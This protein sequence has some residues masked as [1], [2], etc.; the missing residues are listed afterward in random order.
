MASIIVTFALDARGR[1]HGPAHDHA[2]VRPEE[3]TRRHLRA[4]TAADRAAVAAAPCSWMACRCRPACYRSRTWPGDAS[5]PSR[6]ITPADGLSPLQHAFVEH[7]GYQCG[8]CTPGMLMVAS[9]LLDANP[10]PSRADIADAIAGNVCRCTGYRADHR[11][12]RGRGRRAGEREG[13]A[14]W[15]RTSMSSA[16]SVPRSDGIGHVTGRTR[17]AAD[18]TFPGMLH[19]KVVRSPVAPC[20][21][22]GRRPEP[23]PGRAGRRARPHLQDVP[24]NVYTI[25]GLIGVEPEEELVLAQDRV[26]YKGEPIVALLAEIR[27]RGA[28]G[29]GAGPARPRGA[30]GRVR[31][32]GRPAAGRTGRH[33]LGH[34]HVHVRGAPLPP[35]P[36]GRRR[37]RLRRGR[38]RRRGRLRYR[39]RSSRRRSRRPARSPCPRR[40]ADY[41]VYTNTQALYFSLDN[42]SLILDVPGNRLHFVGGTVGGGFGGKVDVIVEPLATLGAMKTGRPVRYVYSRSEEMQVSSTRSAWRIYIKDGVMA[43]GRIVARQVTSYADCGRVQPPDPVCAHEARGQCGRPVRD[44]ERLDR[45]LLRVHEPHPDERHAR[46]RRHDGARSRS[47]SRWTGSP[48]GSVSIRGRSGSS[49]RTATATSSPTASRPRTRPSIETMQAAAALVGHELPAAYRTMTSAPRAPRGR[50]SDD[51]QAAGHGDRRG[52]LPDRHEPRRRPV[53]GSGPRDDERLVRRHALGD[54]PRPGAA[55]GDRPDRRGDARRGPTTTSSSIP[56]TRTPARTTWARSRAGRRTGSATRS[57]WRPARR[58]RRCSRSP[59]RSSR[60]PRRPRDRRPGQRPR[61]GRPGTVGCRSP[62]SPRA[63]SSSTAARSRAGARG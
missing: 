8:Y 55:D 25:L 34:E 37:G 63:P 14:P 47:R 27:G 2:P 50:A 49:T 16:S 51:G 62:I 23:G 12:D 31:R 17:Y 44:P 35:G 13:R 21:D 19:L 28:R 24:N 29:R 3:P 43:D 39:A 42:T 7:N 9:A 26:R 4:A 32:R 1:G 61:P 56:P 58:A 30:A 20:P 48:S 10:S 38:P 5:R 45:R 60:P 54:R 33:P 15:Q 57:S 36:A 18:R 53:A 46:L 6:A 40:M 41:T 11:L 52:Q 22:Q 59:P